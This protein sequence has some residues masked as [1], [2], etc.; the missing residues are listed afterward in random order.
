MEQK[1]KPLLLKTLRGND[2]RR[3]VKAIAELR[4]SSDTALASTVVQA[5][6]PDDQREFQVCVARVVLQ[7]GIN[8]LVD[9]WMTLGDAE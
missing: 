1:H 9:E 4:M 3:A 5:A 8:G 2:F 7:K 6:A